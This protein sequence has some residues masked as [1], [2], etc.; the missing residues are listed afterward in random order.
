MNICFDIYGWTMKVTCNDPNLLEEVRRD[1]SYF[2][3]PEIPCHMTLTMV[4][5][6]P[7]Y[8]DLPDIPASFMTPRNICYRQG[9]TTYV[10]YFGK[11]LGILDE[12]SHTSRMMSEN[13][14]LLHEMVYLYIL[15]SV[16]QYLDAQ[17]LHRLDALGISHK[18]FGMLLMLPSGGGQEHHRATPP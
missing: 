6:P 11:G 3:T 4:R 17:H 10:D 1:F 8:D 18:A 12:E 5:E 14:D 9:T 7:R 13:Y 15:S 2:S 16:G